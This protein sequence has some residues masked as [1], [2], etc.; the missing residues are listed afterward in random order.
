[1][2]DLERLE[3][4]LDLI[5]DSINRPGVVLLNS[6]DLAK[7]LNRSYPIARKIVNSRILKPPIQFVLTNQELINEKLLDE[8]LE[9]PE[10]LEKLKE[11][12]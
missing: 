9:V 5:L 4:K 7:K 6:K 1:M 12:K 11:I 8:W 2:T 10:N 3:S